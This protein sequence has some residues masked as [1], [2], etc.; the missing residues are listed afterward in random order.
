MG[1][2]N[3]I[4]FGCAKLRMLERSR[5]DENG[6]RLLVWFEMTRGDD[7]DENRKVGERADETS[8][9]SLAMLEPHMPPTADKEPRSTQQAALAL[10]LAPPRA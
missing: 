7:D 8:R 4:F 10:I 1:R 6:G 5:M 2:S 9:D 3:A